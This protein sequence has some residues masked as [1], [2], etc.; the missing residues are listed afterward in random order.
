MTSKPIAIAKY[1]PPTKDDR[2]KVEHDVISIKHAGANGN[3]SEPVIVDELATIR[4]TLTPFGPTSCY[5]LVC[6]DEYSNLRYYISSLEN[7]RA[8]LLIQNEFPTKRKI[9]I[10]WN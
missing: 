1:C 7:N 6:E 3:I 10:Y 8:T 5:T 9:T 2:V 4:M